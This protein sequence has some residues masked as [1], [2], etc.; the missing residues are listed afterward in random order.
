MNGTEEMSE[1]SLALDSFRSIK[2]DHVCFES[3]DTKESNLEDLNI[4]FQNNRKYVVVGSSGNGK[5]TLIKNLKDISFFE[6]CKI[7]TVVE[8]DI[9]LFNDTIKHNV[10]LK[11]QSGN[12]Y[13]EFV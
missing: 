6:W 11:K 13:M 4:D 9:F 5:T 3:G 1:R 8:Q 12:R 10:Y 7:I 2:F